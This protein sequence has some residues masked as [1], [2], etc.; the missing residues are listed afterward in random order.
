MCAAYRAY[1]LEGI[2]SI[3]RVYLV[4]I[5]VINWPD[6]AL[7]PE[8]CPDVMVDA[9]IGDTDFL[10]DFDCANVLVK[11]GADGIWRV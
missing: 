6:V 7:W 1:A 3:A 4:S 5:V 2:R 10:L 11:V 8:L 9:A